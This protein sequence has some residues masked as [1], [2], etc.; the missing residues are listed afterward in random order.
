MHLVKGFDSSASAFLL[1]KDHFFAEWEE[2]VILYFHV[3]EIA[4]LF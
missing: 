3:F 2:I 4:F 1:Y